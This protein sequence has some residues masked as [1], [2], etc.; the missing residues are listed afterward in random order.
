LGGV[1][2]RR[3]HQSAGLDPK[4]GNVNEKDTGILW[5]GTF[6]GFGFVGLRQSATANANR[7]RDSKTCRYAPTYFYCYTDS[8]TYR[9]TFADFYF[10][11]DFY[12]NSCLNEHPRTYE[13]P[14]QGRTHRL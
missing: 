3:R 12:N 9:Y 1:T 7:Y 11:S 13:H 8:K 6:S 2:L 5:I 4:T 10:C 14:Q